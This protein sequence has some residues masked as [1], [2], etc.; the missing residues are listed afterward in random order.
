MKIQLLLSSRCKWLNLHPFPI[1]DI[2][3][4][5]FLAESLFSSKPQRK[6]CWFGGM[7]ILFLAHR[8]TKEITI[9][10][11]LHSSKYVFNFTTWWFQIS[12]GS[13][14]QLDDSKFPMF[15]FE[16]VFF[17]FCLYIGNWW[18]FAT[19]SYLICRLLLW[20]SFVI[21]C[22]NCFFWVICSAWA[23]LFV[24]QL[25]QCIWVK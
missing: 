3:F 10:G 22:L 24:V 5:I 12:N 23:M 20:I 4:C 6:T 11:F 8:G 2:M 1:V 17:P 15:Q 7:F 19:S 14:S 21:V 9:M 25:E 16:I 13:I 18:S